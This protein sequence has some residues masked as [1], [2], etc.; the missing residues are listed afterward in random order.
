MRSI[1]RTG[2]VLASMLALAACGGGQDTATN[3]SNTAAPSAP[4]APAGN[5]V[6]NASATGNQAA[7]TATAAQQ[8]FTLVNNTGRIVMTLNV[9]PSD[10]DEWGPDIL[11]ADVV[12]NGQSAQISF[13]RGQ[14]QCN[15]DFRATY[16]DGETTDARGVNLCEVATVTLTGE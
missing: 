8:D 3:T 9:S 16:D 11:G 13:E 12:A 5:S 4:A 15:W 10:S 2:A 1:T 6:E 7:G 14:A